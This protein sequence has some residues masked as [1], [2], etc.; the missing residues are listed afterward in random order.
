MISLVEGFLYITN[1]NFSDRG[2][3][4]GR[5][6]CVRHNFFGPIFV[7]FLDPPLKTLLEP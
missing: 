3:V 4:G 2:H 1:M 7:E 6:V 5:R